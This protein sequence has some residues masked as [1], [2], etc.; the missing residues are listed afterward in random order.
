MASKLDAQPAHGSRFAAILKQQCPSCFSGRV[1]R[2]WLAM[3]EVCPLCG[4][5]FER[6]PGY[7]LGAMYISYMLAI[8]IIGGLTLLLWYTVLASWELVWAALAA[9]GVFLL[10]VPAVFRYSR[11]IWM[12]FDR[13]FHPENV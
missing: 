10:L 2:R 5:R 12:H 7:F 13:Y 8:P 1:F 9:W 11:I 6:E 3:N 4:V